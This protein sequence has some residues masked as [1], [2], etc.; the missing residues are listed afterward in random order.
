MSNY[1]SNI[2]I[3]DLN[4]INKDLNNLEANLSKFTQDSFN[5]KHYRANSTTRNR[6]NFESYAK[7]E[8][9]QSK[10]IN[11]TFETSRDLLNNNTKHKYLIK[12]KKTCLDIIKSRI[13]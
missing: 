4:K 10:L 8:S 2:I 1:N 7:L 5:N 11:S 13:Y 9:F 6:D 3:Y 12:I